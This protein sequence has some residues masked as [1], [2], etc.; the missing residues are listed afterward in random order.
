M[1]RKRTAVR[2]H[3]YPHLFYWIECSLENHFH[4]FLSNS[5]VLYLCQSLSPHYLKKCIHN[6]FLENFL[7]YLFR[8]RNISLSFPFIFEIATTVII[9]FFPGALC[10]SGHEFLFLQKSSLKTLLRYKWHNNIILVLGKQYNLMF[11]FITKC[12]H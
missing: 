9:S 12:S 11:V 2:F 6:V 8:S 3:I 5:H 10:T 4:L 7:F 1:F